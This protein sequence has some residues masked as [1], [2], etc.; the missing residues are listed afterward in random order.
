VLEPGDVLFVPAGSP[1]IVENMDDETVAFSRN[2]VDETN[3]GCVVI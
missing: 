3:L 2:F 1:H